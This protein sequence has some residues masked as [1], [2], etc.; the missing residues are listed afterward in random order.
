MDIPQGYKQT[1]VGVIPED[2][3][4]ITLEEIGKWK[5]GGT[6]SKQNSK[7][8]NGNIPWLSPKD[9]HG[10][11]IAEAED[12]ITEQAITE[13]ST[14]L[15]PKNSILLVTRSSILRNYI[16]VAKNI[17]T[18]AINQDLKALIVDE[19][20]VIDY[21]LQSIKHF[22]GNIKKSAVK[23]GTTVESVDFNSLKR[24]AIPLPPTI[25]E[26]KA[27]AQSL[28]DVDALITAIDQLIT[29]KRNIKQGTMQQLLTGKKRLPGFSSDWE[30]KKLGEITIKIGS[31]ITPTGG[32]KVY[33]TEGRPFVRSQNVGWGKLLLEDIAYI[34][35]VI[36]ETF[37][38]T[39]IKNSDVFLNIT[40]ASIG[41]SA[42]ADKRVENGNVNQ[43]V[44]IIRPIEDEL[45]S[46]FLN[47]LLLSVQGQKKIDSFQAGGNRQGLNFRQ[48][49]SLSFLLPLLTE[50][51]AIAQILR[52]M[53]VEIEGLEKQRE[54][55][56]T[57]KQGIMQ[58]LLTGKTRLKYN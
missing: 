56:K 29:K 2:W 36:H 58:E 57:I 24:F 13:S 6:P 46:Y 16:P 23:V 49:R 22:N 53:D 3:K 41:R 52:N 30:V 5:G 38:E 10:L 51:K 39:E 27:I 35:N 43:H 7:Y 45:D 44:C 15:I 47:S 12:N 28:S 19:T 37:K 34:D 42:I 26:Q 1:D 8:W 33:K 31:G 9:F 50:Q 11:E 48:I 40:G 14:T 54:K 18:V 20:K 32:S 25:E 17:F 55:Y 4:M 21:V